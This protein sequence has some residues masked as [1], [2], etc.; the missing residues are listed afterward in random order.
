MLAKP[1]PRERRDSLELPGLLEK[2]RRARN[3]FQATRRTQSCERHSVHVNHRI[4]VTAYDEQ[5]RRLH[6]W[7][8][9]ASEVRTASARDD[10]ADA[11]RTPCT[12]DQRRRR[13]CTGAE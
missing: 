4:V 12:R 5:R 7:Q 9:I 13:A 10:R 3:Y 2:V 8:R 11:L 1:V 6:E